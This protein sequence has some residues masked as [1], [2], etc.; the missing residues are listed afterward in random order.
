[1]ALHVDYDHILQQCIVQKDCK[2]AEELAISH[3][4]TSW[5]NVSSGV[6]Q[7]G[8]LCMRKYIFSDKN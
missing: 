4:G 6:F 3:I 5:N 1:M 2:Y 7:V 8:D